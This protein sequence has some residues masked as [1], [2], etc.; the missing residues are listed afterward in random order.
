MRIAVFTLFIG[1]CTFSVAWAMT[2]EPGGTRIVA[3]PPTEVVA[4]TQNTACEPLFFDLSH[5]TEEVEEVITEAENEAEIEEFWEEYT[6]SFYDYC[7][8]CCGKW[9]NPNATE[10]V[11]AMGVPL[12]TGYSVASPLPNGTKIEIEGMGVFEVQDKTANWI[13]DKYDGKIIDIFVASHDD[14]PSEGILQRKV[15]IIE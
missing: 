2:H 1:A 6:I 11:G 14:I 5:E 7:E 13:V 8:G 15:R 9:Y 3:E 10:V 12:T 4:V